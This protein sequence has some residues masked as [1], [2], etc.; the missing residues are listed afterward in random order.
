MVIAL[1]HRV[2]PDRNLLLL[3]DYEFL[4]IRRANLRRNESFDP[5]S[6]VIDRCLP[7]EEKAFPS[8]FSTDAGMQIDSSE[9]HSKNA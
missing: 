1:V 7:Q 8:I 6:N 9:E 2:I 5:D 4:R 3:K